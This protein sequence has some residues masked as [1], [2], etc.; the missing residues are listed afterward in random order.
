MKQSMSRRKPA[1]RHSDDAPRGP[2]NP[3]PPLSPKVRSAMMAKRATVEMSF[4]PVEDESERALEAAL[5]FLAECERSTSWLL[6]SERA[7]FSLDDGDAGD[8]GGDVS[9]DVTVDF[10]S[11]TDSPGASGDAED[12]HLELALASTELKTKGRR[13]ARKHSNRAR[14]E[15]RQELVYLRKKVGEMEAQLAELKTHSGGATGAKR[16]DRCSSPPQAAAPSTALAAVWGEMAKRQYQ[17]RQMAEK[18]NVRLKLILER[19][20]KMAKSLE[21][22]LRNRHNNQVRGTNAA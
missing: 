19:Q 2:H 18:E 17:E 8:V 9:G 14:D 13:K 6:G 3:V 10:F 16:R 11:A 1:V 20:L 7:S 22:I 4:L 21:K 5:S 12:A 15:R